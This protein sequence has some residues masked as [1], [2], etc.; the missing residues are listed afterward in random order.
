[1]GTVE[2]ILWLAWWWWLNSCLCIYYFER[3]FHIA[4]AWWILYST[5]IHG[6]MFWNSSKYPHLCTVITLSGLLLRL[7]CS[8][9]NRQIQ[10]GGFE[11]TINFLHKQKYRRLQAVKQFYTSAPWGKANWNGGHS[12]A[13]NLHWIPPGTNSRQRKT[14]LPH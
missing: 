1:M 4:Y 7:L 10:T 14:S 2:T 8:L 5:L 9:S 12:C 6:P 11:K 13:Q 3:G